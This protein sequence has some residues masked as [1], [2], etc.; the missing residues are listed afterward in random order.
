MFQDFL[1]FLVFLCFKIRFPTLFGCLDDFSAYWL[2]VRNTAHH[3]VSTRNAFQC[4]GNKKTTKT[5]SSRSA[6]CRRKH[7]ENW[8]ASQ[9]PR[10][11]GLSGRFLSVANG[12]RKTRLSSCSHPTFKYI[13]SLLCFS[14]SQ[15]SPAHFFTK[16]LVHIFGLSVF[17]L[18]APWS[19][20]FCSKKSVACRVY[21]YLVLERATRLDR[22]GDQQEYGVN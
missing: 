22:I 16:T 19:E 1:L 4:S 9:S 7:V 14:S 2:R 5:P 12:D 13:C 11:C 8:K 20:R 3:A 10:N 21:Y 6:R 15:Q 17:Y 18:S